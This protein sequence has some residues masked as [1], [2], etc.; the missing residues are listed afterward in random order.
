MEGFPEIAPAV[1]DEEIDTFVKNAH[2]IRVLRGRRWGAW[3]ADKE[4]LG[5][6]PSFV[7]LARVPLTNCVFCTATSLSVSPKETATHLGLSA[8]STLLNRAP[9]V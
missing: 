2:H 5:A 8:L 7:A 6:R 4:A 1:S 3:D 9:G